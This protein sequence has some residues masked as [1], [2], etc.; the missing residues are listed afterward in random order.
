MSEFKPES[1]PFELDLSDDD[2]EIVEVVGL[3]EDSPAARPVRDEPVPTEADEDDGTGGEIVLDLDADLN[4][5]AEVV[6]ADRFAKPRLRAR[7]TA[8][9]QRGLRELQEKGRSDRE[10]T[11]RY[12]AAQLVARLLP[13][14]D[15][16][17][18]ALGRARQTGGRSDV[19]GRHRPDLPAAAG[20]AAPG[21]ASWR[22]I[23]WASRSIPNVH[24]A[25]VTDRR[26]RAARQHRCGRASAG[27]S[28]PRSSACG[29]L[30]S[31][32]ASIDRSGAGGAEVSEDA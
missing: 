29:R 14:L 24:E 1:S 26:F 11:E 15:N 25:V 2:I 22:S 4:D 20:R 30:W 8:P 32:S 5:T 19:P 18:R 6:A 12:A 31:R 13:V 9:A 17:E 21:R 27:L 10:A 28:S 7:A 16:F 23:P 3:D